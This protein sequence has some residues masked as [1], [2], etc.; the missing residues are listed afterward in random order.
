MFGPI[1]ACYLHGSLLALKRGL[2]RT[3]S[4]RSRVWAGPRRRNVDHG[5][6]GVARPCERHGMGEYAPQAIGALGTDQEV[7][8]E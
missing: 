1:K 4:F 2:E 3:R 6:P 7:A 8:G 5:Q